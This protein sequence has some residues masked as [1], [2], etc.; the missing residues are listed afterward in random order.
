MLGPPCRGAWSNRREPAGRGRHAGPRG[1]VGVS[2]RVDLARRAAALADDR[3]AFV[4]ATVVRAQRPTSVRPGDA[5]LILGD[6]SIEGFVGGTCAEASVRLHGLRVLETGEPLL[7]R[8]LPGSGEEGATEGAVTVPNPCLSG[9]G[10]EIF[11]EPRLPAARVVVVGDTPIAMALAELGTRVGFDVEAVAALD[12]LHPDDVA[13][14]IA[15]HG[16]GEADALRAA[17]ESDVPYVGLVASPTRGAAVAQ[18]LDLA[19]DRLA[20]LRTPAGLDIGARTPE[21]IALSILAELVASRAGGVAPADPR[22][23]ATTA[24][25][26]DEHH[27]PSPAGAGTATAVDPV[28][29]M[30][31]AASD[32]SAHVERSGRRV[33]F[34]CDHCRRTFEEDPAR[35]AAAGAV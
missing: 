24:T 11:L 25:A 32:L 21:E 28:C 16:R 29:G 6:G 1:A 12:A 35:Y 2:M 4:Q 26:V 3:V 27:H 33:Y 31:V 10:L 17:L 18:A 13:V 9:G 14:V 34:C 23:H 8:I 20:R 19:P 30:T 22:G 5:A 7:L 15:L